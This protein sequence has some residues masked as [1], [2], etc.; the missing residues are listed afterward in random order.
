MIQSVI[1]SAN[2]EAPGQGQTESQG[3]EELDL[4]LYAFFS[5][6]QLSGKS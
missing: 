2:G 6:L 4:Q 1:D 5:V 3:N